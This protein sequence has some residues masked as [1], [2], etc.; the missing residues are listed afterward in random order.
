MLLVPF[1][2]SAQ[3]GGTQGF[4]TSIMSI[5][6]LLITLVAAIALLAFMWGLVKFIFKLGSEA[7]IEGGRNLM[8][9][10]LIALFVMVSVWGIIRFFQSELGLTNNSPFNIT[11]LIN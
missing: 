2:A 8:K 9:W 10:G 1:I 5:V 3:L 6:N 7:D 11:D 4:I